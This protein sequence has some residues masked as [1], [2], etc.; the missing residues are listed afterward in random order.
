M[1]IVAVLGACRGVSPEAE[2]SGPDS[3][4]SAGA[5]LAVSVPRCDE[6]PEVSAPDERYRDAPIYVAN[7]QPTEEVLAWAQMQPGFEELWLD[8]DRLGWITLAFSTDAAAR[9]SDLE[10]LFPD[11]GVVAVAV[12]WTADELEDLQQRVVDELGTELSLSTWGSIQQGVVGIGVGV[13]TPERVAMIEE[14]FGDE[15]ICIEGM[16]AA[17]A[18]APGPQQASGDGWRLLADEQ[19]VGQSYRTGIASDRAS[20]ERLWRDIG[21]A[22]EMPAVDFE[23]EVAVYFGAV[24]GSSCLDLRLDDVVVDRERAL[25]HPEIVLVDPPSFCTEDANPRAYVVALARS[26]LP[27]GPFAIQLS[28]EDPPRGVPEERTLVDVDLSV[29]GSAAGPGDVHG[30]PSLPGPWFTQS[31]D[32]V[33]DGF[34]VPYRFSVHCGI[35]WLGRLNELEWRTDVPPGSVDHVPPEWRAL[36]GADEV[37]EVEILLLTDPEPVI[38]ATAGDITV[39]YRPTSE[40]PPGCE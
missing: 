38:Q 31:G 29:P 36:V 39:T 5:A 16:D 25:V 12:D 28:A 1:A 3:S 20:Y 24:Y 4:A 27:A 13:L 35:E 2:P 18:P 15:R 9:Q 6:V 23:S 30:D 26:R 37:L 7:E 33:E 32:I 21:L 11:I 34:P 22:A 8:R 14:R 19:G 10:R 40:E 17:D